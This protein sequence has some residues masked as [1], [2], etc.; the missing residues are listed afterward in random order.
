MSSHKENSSPGER[1]KNLLK[2]FIIMFFFFFF[3]SSS[4]QTM[5]TKFD[6]ETPYLAQV[7]TKKRK[8]KKTYRINNKSAALNTPVK[9]RPISCTQNC[10]SKH[11]LRN[12]NRDEGGSATRKHKVRKSEREEG[13]RGRGLFWDHFWG[14]TEPLLGP[15]Q[16]Q[17]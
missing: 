7:C 12:Q 17:G 8:K 2:F 4:Y 5:A 6:M 15:L 9:L 11:P 10:S 16:Q 3:F 14:N 1:R 13:G